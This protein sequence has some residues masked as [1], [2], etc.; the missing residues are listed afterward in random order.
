MPRRS[1]RLPQGGPGGHEKGEQP[2]PC[3]CEGF[4]GNEK[5]ERTA[6]AVREGFLLKAP[7]HVLVDQIVEFGVE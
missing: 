3:G 2:Q 5:G 7:G 6:P 1:A 4:R